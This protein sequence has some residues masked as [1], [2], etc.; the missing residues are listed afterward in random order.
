MYRNPK[1]QIPK[2][3]RDILEF[4]FNYINSF[5]THF[6][7]IKLTKYQLAF[8]EIWSEYDQQN[9]G[10]SLLNFLFRMDYNLLWTLTVSAISG[11]HFSR[12][13]DG[14]DIQIGSDLDN[15]AY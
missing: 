2:Y 4:P 5:W 1:T 14:A 8:I 10:S 13:L 7:P 15:L 11:L 9:L 6:S 3:S 12:P